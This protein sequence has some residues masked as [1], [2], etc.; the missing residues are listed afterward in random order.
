MATFL[1]KLKDVA[2]NGFNNANDTVVDLPEPIKHVARKPET[3]SQPTNKVSI[4]TN[5]FG[6]PYVEC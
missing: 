6:F 5:E 1:E 4:K 2:F 3:S